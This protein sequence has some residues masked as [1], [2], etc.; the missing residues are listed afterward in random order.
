[1]LNFLSLLVSN[2]LTKPAFFVGIIVF[3]GLLVIKKP[4]YEAL[5]GFI[6]TAVGFF[7]LTVG[8]NGLSA[9]FRPIVN[10]IGAK[11]EL[12]AAVVDTYFLLGQ[13]YGEG[14]LYS[15]GN[16]VMWTML[17]FIISFVWNFVL[18]IFNKWT[19]CRTLYVTGHTLQWYTTGILWFTYMVAPQ[20]QNLGFSILFGILAGTWAA[21]GSNLTVEATQRLTGNAGF[22]IGHQEMLGIWF[23]D[24][25][26]GVFGGKDQK[27]VEDTKL[28]GFLSI[29]NDNVVSTALLMTIFLGT[30]MA[31]IGRETLMEN[32]TTFTANT[33]MLTYIV[34]TCFHFSVY[35]YILLAGVRMFVSELMKAFDGISK[36]VVKGAMPAVD[37]AVSYNFAH[38]NV[39]LFGFIFGFLGQLVAILGLLVFKSPLFLVPGF[40]P[41]FFDNATVAVYANN[42]GGRRAAMIVPFLNGIFQ[43]V[44]S[45]V[46]ILF[47]QAASGT[48]LT[49][50]PAFF[51]N[52]TFFAAFTVA[53][54]YINPYVATIV[55]VLILLGITQ[56]H[57]RHNK[58]H[59]YDHVKQ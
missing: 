58:E 35:M 32:D 33:L 49:A 31:I 21:V 45:L 42:R 28:P 8:S 40:V 11:F 12:Q 26:A 41:L 10:A 20:T 2:F 53:V 38:P 43:V 48:L 46:M 50:W 34:T 29:F 37:C 3:F 24:K 23:V 54:K 44:I 25:I 4:W 59:Y 57:Y 16:A 51:D 19:R 30:I 55:T 39:P 1:M 14:G 36:K 7:I 6:K 22:A 15:I 52:S 56:I 47:V 27:K 17:S 5:A 9:T 13:M 18:V